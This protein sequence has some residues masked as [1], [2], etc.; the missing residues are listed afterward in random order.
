MMINVDIVVI[1]SGI[2]LSHSYFENLIEDIDGIGVY[3]NE[4]DHTLFYNNNYKDEIGHGTAISYIIKKKFPKCK[5]FILKIFEKELSTD[6]EKLK[7]ALD[8]INK[9]IDCKI[10]HISN[11]FTQWESNNEIFNLCYQLHSKGIIMVSAY[12][13]EG[14]ISYPAFYPFV[15]GVDSDTCCRSTD[16]FIYVEDQHINVKSV[17]FSQRLPWIH[18]SNKQVSGNSFCAPYITCIIYNIIQKG[19]G[20]LKYNDILEELRRKAKK[21]IGK[22]DTSQ[23]SSSKLFQIQKAILFPLNKEIIS[24]SRFLQMYSFQI[25]DIFDI[26]YLRN[27]HTNLNGFIINNYEYIDWESNFDTFIMGHMKTINELLNDDIQKMLIQK[28][29]RY[30]KNIFGFDDLSHY[31]SELDLTN[32][33]GNIYFPVINE[34]AIPSNRFGKMFEISKPVLGVFGTS[35]KQGKFSLQMELKK[36]FVELD[37]SVSALGTEPQALISGFDFCYPL[38]YN[39]NIPLNSYQAILCLNNMMFEMERSDS[40]IIIVGSQSQTLHHNIGNLAMYP[41]Y[42]YEFVV[43]TAPDS[44]IL[45]VNYEDEFDYI[46]KTIRFLESVSESRVLALVLFPFKK[47]SEWSVLSDQYIEIDKSELNIKK[48]DLERRFLLHAYI[49]NEQNDID[50]LFNDIIDFFEE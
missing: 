41:A 24:M 33:T 26:K 10:I 39:S 14:K 46:E 31:L 28:C 6:I 18:N 45:C 7:F 38:G 19:V 11:G 8:Y 3:E 29:I 32:Y 9:N 12:N 21:I 36:R 40:D 35:S 30:N 49:L 27:I 20:V 23:T 2:E 43:G 44:I 37:Y 50:R 25:E 13:N 48:T 22:K 17:L 42:Q 16:E 34:N 15:I 4:N 5:L 47:Y 1:D